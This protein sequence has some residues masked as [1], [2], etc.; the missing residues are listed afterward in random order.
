MNASLPASLSSSPLPIA[1]ARGLSAWRSARAWALLICVTGAALAIDLASKSLA[2]RYLAGSPVVVERAAVFR[3]SAT[4]PR[5]VGA[6]IPVHRPV[7]V[8]P[9]ILDLSL[10]LNPGA[11]FGVGPG[12]R[13][14]FV[15]FTGTALVFGLYM[16]AR[17]T[18][19][20]D[21]AAHAAIGLLLAGGLG[22]LYDRL[23]YGCVRDFLHPLP[24]VRFPFGWRPLGENGEVWPYVSN[25]ADLFL[26]I[27]IGLLLVCLWK[28]AE[29]GAPSPQ[30]SRG[31]PGPAPD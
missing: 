1:G 9:R 20:G 29:P 25:L 8:V 10:V 13:M 12:Q 11:V 30:T 26:I 18:K 3:Q 22:N 23:Q 27:G 6:L 4:D 19:A 21:R 28:R 7:T 16:F 17:W 31:P 5:S 14:F 24:G 2:F 15:V